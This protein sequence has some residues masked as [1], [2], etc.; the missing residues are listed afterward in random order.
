M[1][2]AGLWFG[3]HSNKLD[4]K[5]IGYAVNES[6]ATFKNKVQ[7]IINHLDESIDTF[8]TITINDCYIGL[9]YA[10]ATDE[11]LAFYIDIAQLEG[12]V[13]DPTYTGKAFRGMVKEIQAGKYDDQQAILFIHTG[14]L[15]GYTEETRTRIQQLLPHFDNNL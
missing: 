13:L 11:E 15:Q 7:T 4:T 6:A 14:G 5:I 1:A 2:Y 12:I 10:Q 9:G 3:K 8:D